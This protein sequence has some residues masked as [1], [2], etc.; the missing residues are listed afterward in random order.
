MD[1]ALLEDGSALVSWLNS[2][3]LV[4]QRFDGS[5]ALDAAPLAE[6]AGVSKGYGR[7]RLGRHGQ[8]LWLSWADKAGIQLRQAAAP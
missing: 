1:V 5:G 3:G 7:P 8:S 6:I 4:L 2:R